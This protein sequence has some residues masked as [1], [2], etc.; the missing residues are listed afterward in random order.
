MV[1]TLIKTQAL[2]VIVPGFNSWLVPVSIVVL[3][4][5]LGVSVDGSS[6]WVPATHI[7]NMD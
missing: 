7:G 1:K 2:H 5:I 4:Q 3:M 6:D